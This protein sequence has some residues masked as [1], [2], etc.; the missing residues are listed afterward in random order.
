MAPKRARPDK[1]VL[2]RQQIQ[3]RRKVISWPSIGQQQYQ[4]PNA[5]T[6]GVS[7]FAA[8]ALAPIVR[9]TDVRT[10]IANVITRRMTSLSS[11][12]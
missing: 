4:P 3:S 9:P 6:C 8:V 5:T 11:R 7:A 2:S 1:S 12:A 10:A